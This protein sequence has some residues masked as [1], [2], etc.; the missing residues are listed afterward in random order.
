MN[1]ARKMYFTKAK[2]SLLT[3]SNSQGMEKYKTNISNMNEKLIEEVKDN[4]IGYTSTSSY[5]L[6]QLI[7]KAGSVNELLHIMHSYIVN[8]EEILKAMPIIATKKNEE[9]KSIVLYG[10]ETELSKQVFDDFPLELDCGYTD[11]ISM[12]DRILMMIRDRGHALT[13]DIDNTDKEKDIL[14]KY[15]VPKLC[16]VEMIK[17][18]P[19]IGKFTPN[20][21]NGMFETK[22][23]ELSK[24]LFN[25]IEKVPTDADMPG[26]NR[27]IAEFMLENRESAEEKNLKQSEDSYI[28]GEDDVK[29]MATEISPKGRRTGRITKLRERI[30]NAVK[31]LENK[32]KVDKKDNERSDLD[33]RD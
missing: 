25:F 3:D 27:R 32:F 2:E 31:G 6:V 33:D 21:A 14:V 5:D 24:R 28:F 23:E 15:F 22:S 30:Q 8:N 29:E 9:N 11:I 17:E 1:E 16:N 4:C 20:G 19:G 7:G 10:E 12:Q 18:L 13:I 26:I